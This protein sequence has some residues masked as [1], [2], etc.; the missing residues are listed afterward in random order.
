MLYLSL[1]DHA[2]NMYTIMHICM[3]ALQYQFFIC[4]SAL[5]NL[6]TASI[7][8]KS[9]ISHLCLCLIVS[10]ILQ[11]KHHTFCV[12]L[13]ICKVCVQSTCVKY[14]YSTFSDYSVCLMLLIVALILIEKCHFTTNMQLLILRH[15]H[16][17]ILVIFAIL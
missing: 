8:V 15:F 13:C 2:G 1:A 3:K 4:N 12:Q 5:L 10:K 17:E 11:F 14:V 9:L 6:I 16:P 7:S